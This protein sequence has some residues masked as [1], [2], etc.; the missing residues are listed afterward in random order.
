MFDQILF[1]A[2]G[3]ALIVWGIQIKNK[4]DD[5]GAYMREYFH[6]RPNDTGAENAFMAHRDQRRF[7]GNLAIGAGVFLLFFMLK[8]TF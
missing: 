2:I 6:D 3:G 5:K 1:S 7:D 8:S 4:A